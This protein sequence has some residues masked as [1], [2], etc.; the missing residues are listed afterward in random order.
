LEVRFTPFARRQFQEILESIHADRPGAAV[1]FLRRVS[2]TLLRLH[3]FPGSGRRIP[4]FL[5]LPYREILVPPYRLFYLVDDDV[6]WVVAVWH[7]RQSPEPPQEH[8]STS[9]A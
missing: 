2:S 9:S 8:R 7:E 4:E 6:V 3:D 5:T 1:A